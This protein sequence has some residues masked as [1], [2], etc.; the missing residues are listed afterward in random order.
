MFAQAIALVV[1]ALGFH[2]VNYMLINSGEAL[3]YVFVRQAK[4]ID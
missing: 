1:I 2:M 4:Q 3:P